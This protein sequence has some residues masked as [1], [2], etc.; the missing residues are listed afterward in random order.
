MIYRLSWKPA[1][2]T[3]ADLY[4]SIYQLSVYIYMYIHIYDIHICIYIY[5][6]TYMYIHICIYIYVYTYIYVYIYIYVYTYMYIIY[7]TR[8]HPFVSDFLVKKKHKPIIL[9]I[10]QWPVGAWRVGG[11]RCTSGN[12]WDSMD[13]YPLVINHGD[14]MG[15][16]MI[17]WD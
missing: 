6:Y 5:V 15:F 3:I 10:S 9:G 4:V 7:F 11:G 17:S 16:I 14:S 1:R 12:D 13:S 8:F 2:E